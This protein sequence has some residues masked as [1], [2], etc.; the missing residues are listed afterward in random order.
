MV[1]RAGY[2][3]TKKTYCRYVAENSRHKHKLKTV[4]GTVLF[5]ILEKTVVSHNPLSSNRFQNLVFIDAAYLKGK[6][7][8]ITNFRTF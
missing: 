7:I 3:R 5:D 6:L 4:E 1:T 8:F 2:G